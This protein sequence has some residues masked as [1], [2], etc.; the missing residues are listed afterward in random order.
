[1]SQGQGL[2]LVVRGQGQGLGVMVY[3][4]VL[5]IWDFPQGLGL[6]CMVRV[7][8]QALGLRGLRV[9][10]QVYG[11]GF[12]VSCLCI[13]LVARVQSVSVMSQGQC[14]ELILGFISQGQGQCYELVLVL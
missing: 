2:V 3:G 1:M 8:G 9:Y 6:M 11:L 12:R 14:Y 10:V 7:Q 5:G 4:Q 13:G